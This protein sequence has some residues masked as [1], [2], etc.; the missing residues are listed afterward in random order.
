M[1]GVRLSCLML[2]LAVAIVGACGSASTTAGGP[3]GLPAVGAPGTAVACMTGTWSTA[4]AECRLASCAE[5]ATALN[6][7]CSDWASC[8][9]PNGSTTPSDSPACETYTRG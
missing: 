1:T 9:C 6:D 4:C 7:A 2:L 5:Q 3:P 8:A